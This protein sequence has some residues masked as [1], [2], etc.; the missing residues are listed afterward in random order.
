MLRARGLAS[1]TRLYS[2]K[3]E[4]EM[5][6]VAHDATICHDFISNLPL[7]VQ[8]LQDVVTSNAIADDHK[9]K[10][11]GFLS[12]ISNEQIMLDLYFLAG[13]TRILKR[14]STEFQ[15]KCMI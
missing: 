9:V 11:E 2:P 10:A 5:K 4:K 15:V 1:N 12:K 13:I 14:F 3:L 7:Y 6:F 8:A